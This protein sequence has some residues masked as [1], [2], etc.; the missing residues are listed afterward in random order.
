MRSFAV[1]LSLALVASA[2]YISQG[3][4]PGQAVTT[5][6]A[7]ATTTSGFDPK[8]RPGATPAAT[9]VASGPE[10]SFW[11]KLFAEGPLGNL[12][13]SKG[14]NVSAAI[15]KARIS[16]EW[17]LRIPIIYDENYA[18]IIT[19]ET[20]TAEEE[21]QRVWFIVVSGGPH[22]NAIS[23]YVDKQ[24]DECYNITQIENDLP[25][26]RFARINY[27]EVTYITTKWGLWKAPALVVLTDRGKTLR[28]YYS[29]TLNTK[30][31]TL[32]RFL[33]QEAWK[34]TEPWATQYAPGG[35]REYMM[36]F[37]AIW[38]MKGYRLFN[39]VPRF[40]FLMATGGLTSVILSF[41]HRGG[42]D[43]KAQPAPRPPPVKRAN[44][45][46]VPATIIDPNETASASDSGTPAPDSKAPSTHAPKKRKGG[47][48]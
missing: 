2:N 48:K 7:A 13:Q 20:M 22:G 36:E 1:V 16:E 8:R 47:K 34:D 35:E 27:M 18:E 32:H 6:P 25:H 38:M 39:A 12:L 26:V 15:E 19:N 40:V 3:W 24:F 37:V 42:S 23:Q 46:R 28:F 4:Q 44:L 21:K 43:K 33:L 41:L 31:A 30:A 29:S 11:T 45:R 9:P 5:K 10:S 14:V 17:D